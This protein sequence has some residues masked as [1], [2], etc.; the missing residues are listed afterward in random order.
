MGRA[1]ADGLRRVADRAAAVA[2]V[3]MEE[4]EDAAAVRGGDALA[5][6]AER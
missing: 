2:R 3:A 4:G 1:P 6:A 5:A